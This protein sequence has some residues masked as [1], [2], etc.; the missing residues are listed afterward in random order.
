MVSVLSLLTMKHFDNKQVP[1]TAKLAH[2]EKIGFQ[3]LED[4]NHYGLYN[5]STPQALQGIAIVAMKR[6]RTLVF[7][8]QTATQEDLKKID[9]AIFKLST[10]LMGTTAVE[11]D[12]VC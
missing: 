2:L 9:K 11:E 10:A 6:L 8:M 3:T 7:H 12:D 5:A 1:R 4:V